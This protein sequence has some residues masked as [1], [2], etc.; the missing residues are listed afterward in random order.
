MKGISGGRRSLRGL[1]VQPASFPGHILRNKIARLAY[2]RTRA[3]TSGR[4]QSIRYAPPGSTCCCHSRSSSARS[5][6]SASATRMISRKSA[7]PGS[8]VLEVQEQLFQRNLDDHQL[9]FAICVLGPLKRAP[10]PGGAVGVCD[11]E[12]R[13]LCGRRASEPHK[14]ARSARGNRACRARFLRHRSGNRLRRDPQSAT[15]RPARHFVTVR[16][17]ESAWV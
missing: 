16:P 17:E 1:C 10:P 3:R 8:P 4:V 6:A 11:R 12:L 2:H 9:F 5:P 13:Q 7:A 14:P 15:G